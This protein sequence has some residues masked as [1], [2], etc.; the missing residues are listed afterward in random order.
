[1]YTP[2]ITKH[3]I[4]IILGF[5]SLSCLHIIMSLKKYLYL[6]CKFVDLNHTKVLRYFE[7]VWA[8]SNITPCD[9]TDGMFHSNLKMGYDNDS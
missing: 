9:G 4:E 1:M 6:P 7:M 2:Y 3:L 5:L 8:R